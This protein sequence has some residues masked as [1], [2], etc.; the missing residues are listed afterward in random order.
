MQE[1]IAPFNIEET[2]QTPCKWCEDLGTT[3]IVSWLAE[4]DEKQEMKKQTK[5]KHFK[6]NR[7]TQNTQKN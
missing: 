7:D 2:N 6:K 4:Q 3:E 5:K 1:K